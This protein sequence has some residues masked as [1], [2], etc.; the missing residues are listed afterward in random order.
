MK[1]GMS[2]HA[3]Q[4]IVGQAQLGNAY[5]LF[6]REGRDAA[7]Y[8]VVI[9]KSAYR[10]LISTQTYLENSDDLMDGGFMVVAA[11]DPYYAGSPLWTKSITDEG[12]ELAKLA[13]ASLGESILR[14]KGNRVAVD[15]LRSN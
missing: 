10:F 1:T 11:D 4:Y 7:I 14:V 8:E 13:D 12:K 6:V 3:K 5:P 15:T 2:D 9:E